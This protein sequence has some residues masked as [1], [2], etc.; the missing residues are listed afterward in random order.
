MK[1]NPAGKEEIISVT[2]TEE[3]YPV[4]YAEKLKELKSAGVTEEEARKYIR[5]TPIILEIY[6]EKGRGL[7]AVES[8]A[9]ECSATSI[10]SPY[11]GEYFEENEENN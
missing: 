8:D 6:Y 9:L 3:K 10:M 11:S 1:I 5:Q 7:F 2:L 4:A